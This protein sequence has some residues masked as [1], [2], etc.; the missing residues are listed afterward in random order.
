[1]TRNIF[2]LKTLFYS[3]SSRYFSENNKFRNLIKDKKV[4]IVGPAN[5]L[6]HFNWGKN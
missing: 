3:K 5:Y 6:T 1:M 2:S 4:A